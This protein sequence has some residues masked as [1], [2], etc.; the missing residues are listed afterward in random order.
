MRGEGP[1]ADQMCAA[2][3]QSGE[4][5]T[6]PVRWEG[7]AEIVVEDGP[8]RVTAFG[9][10]WEG[11]ESACTWEEVAGAE[12]AWEGPAGRSASNGL[13]REGPAVEEGLPA[14]PQVQVAGRAERCWLR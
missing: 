10:A 4:V 13:A 7:V 2:M 8:G 14:R 11:P 12:A 5:Q 9:P 3:W 6:E 1:G